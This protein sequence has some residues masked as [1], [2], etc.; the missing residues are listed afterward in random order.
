MKTTDLCNLVPNET[1]LRIRKNN[2]NY[3]VGHTDGEFCYKNSDGCYMV[4][5]M[6]NLDYIDI[7]DFE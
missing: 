7:I 6:V 2:N 1:R 5:P 3:Y 4:E